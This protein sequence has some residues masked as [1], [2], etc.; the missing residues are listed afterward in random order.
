MTIEAVSCKS[1]TVY[2]LLR[3]GDRELH[4][5]P[6]ASS[7]IVQPGGFSARFCTLPDRVLRRAECG[8]LGKGG[9]GKER[10]VLSKVLS[11]FSHSSCA[12][13]V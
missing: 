2:S 8:R 7:C 10:L 5:A 3:Y 13:R 6:P 4:S 12:V 1:C 11:S 9:N